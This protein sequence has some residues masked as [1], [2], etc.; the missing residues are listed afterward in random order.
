MV[1]VTTAVY[2][3]Y[4]PEGNH[5]PGNPPSWRVESCTID[6]ESDRPPVTLTSDWVYASPDAAHDDMKQQALER[7]RISGYTVSVAEIVWRLHMIG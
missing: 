4:G 7:M 6:F 5:T 2:K 3:D 1:H